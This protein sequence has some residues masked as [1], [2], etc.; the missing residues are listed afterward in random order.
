MM[1]SIMGDMMRDMM[2]SIMGDMMR[3]MVRSIMG[4]MIGGTPLECHPCLGSSDANIICIQRL[5]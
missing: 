4:D 1:R 2:R 3:D 5:A